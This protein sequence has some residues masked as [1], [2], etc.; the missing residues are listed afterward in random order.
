[1]KNLEP[2]IVVASDTMQG[3]WIQLSER[4][5]VS[6]TASGN[7]E[8]FAVI[9]R[10]YQ[11]RLVRTAFRITKNAS[12]AE[13]IVQEALLK[14]YQKIHTFHFA[15][16]LLTWLTQIVINCGFMELRRRKSRPWLS[17]DDVNENGISLMELVPDLTN[18]V[19][20]AV[21]LKEQLQ[22]LAACIARLPPKL[23]IVI[24]DYRMSEPTMAELAH[25]HA[26]TVTAAKSRLLRAKTAIKNSRRILNAKP[27]SRR[28]RG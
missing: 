24:E 8:A 21:C 3:R 28:K 9:C 25:T 5:L 27:P 20:E 4:E 7:G 19:E 12:D 6:L 17:L 16:S 26:I 10:R 2:S 23:R 18:D 14:A 22:V 1:M 13:D 15:S 11:Q